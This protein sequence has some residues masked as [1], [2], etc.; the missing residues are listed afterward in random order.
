MNKNLLTK[1][2]LIIAVLI[3]FLFGIIGVPASY[4]GAGLAQALIA[5]ARQDKGKC[6]PP[7]AARDQK[8]S[9]R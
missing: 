6:P 2:V 4:N 7:N 9:E 3:V 8:K 1:T 5:G